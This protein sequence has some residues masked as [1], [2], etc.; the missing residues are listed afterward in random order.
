MTSLDDILRDVQRGILNPSEASNK[1]TNLFNQ[2][3]QN[4]SSINSFAKLDHDRFVR[5]NF[6]EVVFAEGKTAPQIALILDDMARSVNEK[7]ESS[8]DPL[9]VAS[10]AILATR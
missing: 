5:T 3:A 4:G 1:I 7:I 8:S 10:T 9:D 2:N 6:P